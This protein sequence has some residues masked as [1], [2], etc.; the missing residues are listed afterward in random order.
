MPVIIGRSD[1]YVRRGVDSWYA[2]K[3]RSVKLET[4]QMR[5]RRLSFLW[6]GVVL[7]IEYNEQVAPCPLTSIDVFMFLMKRLKFT[8]REEE[9]EDG[10]VVVL[11]REEGLLGGVELAC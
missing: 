9:E 7:R 3:I 6:L 10:W 4:P 11:G 8:W 2:G 5:V 1:V